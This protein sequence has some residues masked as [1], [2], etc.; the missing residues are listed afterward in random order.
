MIIINFF[1]APGAGKSTGAAY[2][3]ARLKM[4]GVN[5]EF[6]T[7][8]IK[9]AI[10]E[11]GQSVFNEQIKMLGEQYLKIKSCEDKV[12]VL[13]T[14]SSLINGYFYNSNSILED[15]LKRLSL[16]LF[17]KYNNMNFFINRTKPYIS[18]GRSQTEAESNRI[19]IEI[20]QTLN[21]LG[22]PFME[23]DGDIV[24]Y[25]AITELILDDVKRKYKIFEEIAQFDPFAKEMIVSNNNIH[26]IKIYTDG[27]CSGNPGPGGWSAII[28][29][30]GVETELSGYS[31]QTTNNRME[32][33]AVINALSSVNLPSNV[34]VISDSKYVCDAVNKDWIYSWQKNSWK[35]A[36][37]KPVLNVDLW[38]QLLPL[39]KKHNVKFSWV[40]GHSGN[41]Y[42]ERCDK[43][44]VAEYRPYLTK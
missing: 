34:E 9:D 16:D 10:W 7:E 41:Y 37:K 29:E 38:M 1:G 14:D 39:L 19:G 33:T 25:N 42:N 26:D 12:D 17:Y 24:S 13:I 43:L 28:I 18:E 2:V 20:K 3:F 8:S 27:A 35:K 6:I 21:K 31:P 40:K 4:A 30:N 44:A 36:N 5:C 32:I 22:I 15:D 11:K 23:Y